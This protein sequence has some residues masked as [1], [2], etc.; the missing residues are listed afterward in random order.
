MVTG[1]PSVMTPPGWEN[2]GSAAAGRDDAVLEA[3]AVGADVAVLVAARVIETVF[4]AVAAAVAVVD[5]RHAHAWPA[6]YAAFLR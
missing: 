5:A 4:E 1:L 2:V 6:S 3:V